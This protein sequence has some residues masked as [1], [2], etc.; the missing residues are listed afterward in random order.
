MST[1]SRELTARI[2]KDLAR[3]S[4]S[5]QVIASRY[6]VPESTV[7][8]LRDFYGPGIPQLIEADE[9]LRR[10][11]KPVEGTPPVGPLAVSGTAEDVA[12]RTEPEPEPEPEDEEP[13]V[14]PRRSDGLTSAERVDCRSWCAS[15]GREVGSFGMIARD[16]VD[17]WD[18][19]GRPLAPT[20]DVDDVIDAEVV[21][22]TE[23]DNVFIEQLRSAADLLDDVG[24][25]IPFAAGHLHDEVSDFLAE[26]ARVSSHWQAAR[27][28][29]HLVGRA[30]TALT[31]RG[32]EISEQQ[33]REVL[34]ELELV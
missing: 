20:V 12:S 15:T 27:E 16:V 30:Q 22:G 8:A 28:A 9:E 4:R 2:V 21:E 31:R 5:V 1:L 23:A 19:A 33:V 14:K 11:S 24:R 3:A 34:A 13:E 26:V 17:A 18:A 6:R 7:V 10:V 29:Q 25:L 32:V